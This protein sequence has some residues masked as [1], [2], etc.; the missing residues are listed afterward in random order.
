MSFAIARSWKPWLGSS[1]PGV[2]YFEVIV[3]AVLGRV[4]TVTVLEVQEPLPPCPSVRL[5]RL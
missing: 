1:E 2:R 5:S 4:V 3:G